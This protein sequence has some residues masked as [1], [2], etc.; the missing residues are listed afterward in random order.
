[1]FLTVMD[2]RMPN[3]RRQMYIHYKGE[4]GQNA[5][6]SRSD[7]E[8][9]PWDE[10][11]VNEWWWKKSVRAGRGVGTLTCF[12]FHAIQ[13]IVFF[14]FRYFFPRCFSYFATSR[15]RPYMIS[16]VSR[17]NLIESENLT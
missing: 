7:A 12:N 16:L 14:C 15:T 3:R 10:M 4:A 1:M 17:L 5:K 9:R 11:R 13:L 8:R 2:F 6:K